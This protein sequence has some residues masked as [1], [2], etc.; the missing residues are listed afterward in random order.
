M[1]VAHAPV[2]QIL[3]QLVAE[4]HLLAE[5]EVVPPFHHR[6]DQLAEAGL[7]VQRVYCCVKMADIPGF[8]QYLLGIYIIFSLLFNF[9]KE[10]KTELDS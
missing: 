4:A 7:D 8:N 5:G 3:H 2:S 6:L 9:Q 1:W 10:R